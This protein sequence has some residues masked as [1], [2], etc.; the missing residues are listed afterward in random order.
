MQSVDDDQDELLATASHDLRNPLATIKTQAQILV[1]QLTGTCDVDRDKILQRVSAMES[2]AD[3]MSAQLDD[4]IDLIGAP[5]N[6]LPSP[7]SSEPVNLV[8]LVQDTVQAHQLATEER[9]LAFSAAQPELVI[10]G[11]PTVRLRRILD[12]LI[13][14]AVKY[15]TPGGSVAVQ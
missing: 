15:T 1:R 9:T 12:N 13:G 5:G 10:T 2:A 11:H 4:L 14:N 6:C 7:R 8:Q 3:R